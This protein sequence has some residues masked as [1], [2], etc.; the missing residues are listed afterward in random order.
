MGAT[1]HKG[2]IEGVLAMSRAFGNPDLKKS[3]YLTCDPDITK[4]AIN[5]DLQY[6]I[7]ASDGLWDVMSAK[8]A[9][10]YLKATS[11]ELSPEMQAQGL[12]QHAHRSGS[13]DNISVV[14]IKFNHKFKPAS[15]SNN[16]AEPATGSAEIAPPPDEAAR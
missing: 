11:K 5:R 13:K 15:P 3:H 4:T 2:R 12:A 6:V 14:V 8:E 1:V 16:T 10:K 7:L 9:C